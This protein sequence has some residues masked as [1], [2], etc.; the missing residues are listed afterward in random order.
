MKFRF[1]YP[2][3]A[4]LLVASS[5]AHADMLVTKPVISVTGDSYARRTVCGLYTTYDSCDLAG[6]VKHHLSY[7]TYLNAGS[8]YK[9]VMT[10]N[11]GRGGDTC[12]T[13]TGW[14]DG[15]WNGQS[16][17]L[18]SQYS[19]RILNRGSEAVSILI[20]INDVNLYGV[21]ETG[22]KNC[23]KSLYLSVRSNNLK[24]IAMTYPPVSL[25]TM[26]WGNGSLA[27]YNLTLVNNAI[28]SAVNEHNLQYPNLPVLLADTNKAWTIG[29][30]PALTEDGAHPNQSGAVR[31]ARTWYTEVCGK[32]YVTLTCN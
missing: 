5:L 23:L 22:L 24:V 2:F 11:S 27:S 32:G 12:T 3:A 17:G 15:P 30:T 4:T 31:L 6:Q 21:T 18:L 16:R 29:E 26:V 14:T 1:S 20:G 10:D 8:K 9:V 25:D 13:Q 19:T 28:R 7:S